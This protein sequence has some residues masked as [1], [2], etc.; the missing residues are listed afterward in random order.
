MR[1]YLGISFACF[2]TVAL[3]AGIAVAKQRTV[4]QLSAPEVYV[5]VVGD[6]DGTNPA[7]Q[8]V[9][10]DTVWIADWTFETGVCDGS[11]GPFGFQ[12]GD[13]YIRDGH[14]QFEPGLSNPVEWNID[15][16]YDTQGGIVG[17][18]G[19]CGYINDVCAVDVVGGYYNG[20]YQIGRAHV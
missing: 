6:I 10:Q 8:K 14:G 17:D 1:R 5:D 2:C 7:P 13:N 16:A 11:L 19:R 18:A 20:M 4:H 12:K 3:V 15:N 9:L